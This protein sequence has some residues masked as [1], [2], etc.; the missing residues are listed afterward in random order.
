MSTIEEIIEGLP[1]EFQPIATKLR[2]ALRSCTEDNLEILLRNFMNDSTMA[3]R[4]LAK[5]GPEGAEV[6]IE[7]AIIMHQQANEVDAA[8]NDAFEMLAEI[9]I[10][11][12]VA[13]AVSAI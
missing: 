13:A 11:I 4:R 6:C 2:L 3:Y 7:A 5:S 12:I 8:W 1:G 10:K 9:G